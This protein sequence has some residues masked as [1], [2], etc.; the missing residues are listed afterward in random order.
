MP[1]KM[2]VFVA[3]G[4][5]R[6]LMWVALGFLTMW[7]GDQQP[8]TLLIVF[9]VM[10]ALAT[11]CMGITNVPWMDI[12]GKSVPSS[13]RARMFAVRR[14]VGGGVAMLSGGLISWMLSERSGLV[15]PDNCAML[16]ILSGVGTGLSI[17]AFARIRE[18]VQ[19]KQGKTLPL[20]EYLKVGLGLL[21]EDLNYRRL[22]ILQ[23]L[24]AFS[25]M[26]TPF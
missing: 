8:T 19:Q 5:L 7:L 6:T 12:I 14:L 1:R 21:K 2:P 24:W 13:E 18:P 17:L 20:G 10:Y 16:F 11:P 26:A 23:F 25:M 15:F 3:A 9:M 4:T 22:C